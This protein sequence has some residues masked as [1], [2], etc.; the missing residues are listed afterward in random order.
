M[1]VNVPHQSPTRPKEIKQEIC[2]EETTVIKP[3]LEPNQ[4]TEPLNL[5]EL[6]PIEEVVQ[7]SI[8][9][10]TDTSIFL[11]ALADVR[12]MHYENA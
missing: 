11:S 9:K 12:Q 6:Q 5:P 2:N 1:P 10:E 4:P 8:K 3:K 7:E